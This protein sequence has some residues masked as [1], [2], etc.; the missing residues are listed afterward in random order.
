MRARAALPSWLLAVLVASL[1]PGA[2]G[3]GGAAADPRSA[4]LSAARDDL[5]ELRLGAA[6]AAVSDVLA[7]PDLP[8]DLRLD[9]LVLRSQVHG[10]SGDLDATEED[11]RQILVLEPAFRPDP[12]LTSRKAAARFDAVRAAM[13]GTVRLL[14]DPPDAVVRFDGRVASRSAEGV[15]PA[16]PGVRKLRIERRGFDAEE[17]TVD[18]AVGREVSVSVRLVP[19]ARTVVFRTEPDEVRV[20][21]DGR[22]VGATA[23]PRS[24]EGASIEGQPAELRLED[25]P[26]GEHAFTLEKS[27]FRTVFRRE[28][29]AVDLMDSSPLVSEVIAMVPVVSALDVRGSVEDA[30]VLVDGKPAGALPQEAIRLCPGSRDVEVRARGRTVFRGSLDLE[31][32]GS[33]VLEIRPRPNLA[34]AGVSSVPAGFEAL[35]AAT[36]AAGRVNLP[37]SGDPGDAAAWKG[38]D[39]PAGVDLVLAVEPASGLR[40]ARALLYSPILRIAEPVTDPGFGAS[41]PSWSRAVFGLRVADGRVGG[42]SRVVEVTPAGPASAAGI[43]AGDRVLAVGAARVSRA[44]EVVS[45]LRRQA[46]GAPVEIEVQAPGAAPR[47]IRVTPAASPLCGETDAGAPDAFLAAWAAS[48]GAA[49]GEGAAAALANL[50]VLLARHGRHEEALAVWSRVDFGTRSGIGAGTVDYLRSRSLEALGREAEA[51]DALLRA[52]SSGATIV[53]DEGLGVAPAAGDRL[54]DLGLADG[55]DRPGPAAIAR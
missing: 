40:A 49:A 19:N 18:V 51:R 1:C 22:D 39:V 26:L 46:P 14:L 38:T 50:A 12:N 24:P 21:V 8:D 3:E 54:V 31:E 43:R 33:R 52:R 13:L 36:S 55:R 41:R 10:A 15:Y 35:A 48:D 4:V 37:D 44:A 32:G 11:Y 25:L 7:S 2:A 17:R 47:T 20:L 45:A 29:L 9:A 5:A 16:L 34:L 53:D 27:C 28:M 6:L 42:A 30:E 23:R